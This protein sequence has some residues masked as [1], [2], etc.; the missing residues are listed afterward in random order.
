MHEYAV[1]LEQREGASETQQEELEFNEEKYNR[2]M[3]DLT[4]LKA[5]KQS[6]KSD[7]DVKKQ[8]VAFMQEKTAAEIER[9]R[10]DK[11]N[12]IIK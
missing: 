4:E 9:L 2:L 5:M 3:G 7:S 11:D 10:R 1:K 8:E 6:K 12:L